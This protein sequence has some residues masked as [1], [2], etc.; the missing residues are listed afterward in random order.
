MHMQN[1]T[2]T[3]RP[4]TVRDL[5]FMSPNLPFYHLISNLW[6]QVIVT[7]LLN[8]NPDVCVMN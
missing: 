8:R 2:D 3:S 5:R 6:N 4:K 1:R 7:L